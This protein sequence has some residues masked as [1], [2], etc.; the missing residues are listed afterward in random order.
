MKNL[1]PNQ[2]P[3]IDTLPDDSVES[4]SEPLTPILEQE[5]P[6]QPDY[7]DDDLVPIEFGASKGKVA[8][9]KID[10][11]TSGVRSIW[12]TL[13]FFFNYYLITCLCDFVFYIYWVYGNLFRK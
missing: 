7:E 9:G 10:E 11:E 2:L 4:P 3:E 6:L 1:E 8:F 13:F 5:N 12:Q